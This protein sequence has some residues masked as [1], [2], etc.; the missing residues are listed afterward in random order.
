[1]CQVAGNLWM[2]GKAK[3]AVLHLHHV[4]HA[5]KLYD[6]L[7]ASSE[8]IRSNDYVRSELNLEVSPCMHAVLQWLHP[9]CKPAYIALLKDG[10]GIM[11]KQDD[12]TWGP[13]N[14]MWQFTSINGQDCLT[15]HFHWKGDVDN[16]GVPK[17]YW[18]LLE[19]VDVPQS[20]LVEK[21][22]TERQTFQAIGGSTE[23]KSSTGQI[24]EPG[25]LKSWHIVAQYIWVANVGE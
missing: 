12:G 15:C 13:A 1:M 3:D 17:A 9:R 5:F 8:L 20:L 11:M 10:K 24:L 2:G 4:H 6:A 16:A 25:L 18:T 21:L 14:G 7:K 19:K 22:E 23:K